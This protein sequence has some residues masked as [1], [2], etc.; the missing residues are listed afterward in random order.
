M[1]AFNESMKATSEVLVTNPA[2]QAEHPP[3]AHEVE[4]EVN[5]RPA[6]VPART[7]GAAI[8]AAAGVPAD[9]QLFRIEGD[10]EIAVGDNETIEV[11]PGERFVATPPIEPA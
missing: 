7:T 9:D 1:Y 6:R 2:A 4:I 11:H 8:K 5:K 10:R 3:A